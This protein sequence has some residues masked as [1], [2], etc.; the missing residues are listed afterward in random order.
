MYLKMQQPLET[1]LGQKRSQA[2]GGVEDVSC[3]GSDGTPWPK[4]GKKEDINGTERRGTDESLMMT[5]I[6]NNNTG[7]REM[8]TT[9]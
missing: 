9:A 8:N 1:S 5:K 6:L 4:D 2:T 3:V 7:A